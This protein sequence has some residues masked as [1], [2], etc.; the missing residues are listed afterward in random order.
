MNNSVR[1][2]DV[3]GSDQ[4]DLAWDGVG[5]NNCF[6]SNMFGTS[7]PGDIQDDYGCDR[8]PFTGTN[9]EPVYSDAALRPADPERE[10]IPPPSP[11]RPRCQ[12]GVPS[13][14]L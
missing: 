9:F 2:N 6:A 3:A 4:Y 5:D 12:R 8:K 7:G 13:C 1:E 10:E 11:K 14:D